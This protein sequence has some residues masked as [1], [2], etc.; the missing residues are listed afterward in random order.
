M[1]ADN[2]ILK[3]QTKH[4]GRQNVMIVPSREKLFLSPL[5]SVLRYN[6]SEKHRGLSKEVLEMFLTL[7]DTEKSLTQFLNNRLTDIFVKAQ[8]NRRIEDFQ[9]WK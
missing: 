9:S 6:V 1:L 4:V 7:T 2:R 5:V 8:R 3:W